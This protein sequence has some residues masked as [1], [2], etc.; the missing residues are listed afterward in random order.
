VTNLVFKPLTPATW[1]AYAA[2]VGRNNGLFGGCWCTWFHLLPDPP[3][4]EALGNAEFKRKLVEAYPH[5]LAEKKAAGKKV[6]SSFLYNATRTLYEREGFTY[7]RPK[8]LGNC[9]MT[10]QVAPVAPG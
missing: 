3:E 10:K 6:S 8:G 7:L 4:R 5:D 9:V 2:M 1:P